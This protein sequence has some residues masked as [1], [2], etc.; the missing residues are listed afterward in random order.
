MQKDDRC[1]KDRYRNGMAEC[2][3]QAKS[4]AF[5]PGALHA[6]DIGNGSEMVVIEAVA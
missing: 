2:V 1:P 4:H 5:A 3:E 6:R